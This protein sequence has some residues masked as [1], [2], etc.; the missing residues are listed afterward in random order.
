M[1]RP[2]AVIPERDWEAD[3][4]D[5][6]TQR[7]QQTWPAP[8]PSVETGDGKNDAIHHEKHREP[9][10][11]SEDDRASPE[12]WPP[13]RSEREDSADGAGDQEVESYAESAGHPAA[14]VRGASEKTAGDRLRDAQW[15]DSHARIE[16]NGVSQ[17]QHTD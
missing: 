8:W 11:R 2:Q 16:Q 5:V 12:R 4:E 17:V 1:A 7:V 14:V 9:I 6:S 3:R 10:E 13:T 15:R